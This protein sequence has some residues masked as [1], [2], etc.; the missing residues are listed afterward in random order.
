MG[1]SE[2]ENREDLEIEPDKNNWLINFETPCPNPMI[3]R[4]W[5]EKTSQFNTLKRVLS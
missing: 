5:T 3:T 4:D 1:Y 2:I